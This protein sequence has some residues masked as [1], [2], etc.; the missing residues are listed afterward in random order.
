MTPYSVVNCK[1]KMTQIYLK[2]SQLSSQFLKKWI[3]D[4]PVIGLKFFE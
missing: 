4:H 2:G 3:S 1:Q